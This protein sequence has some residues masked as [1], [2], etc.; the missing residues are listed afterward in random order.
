MLHITDECNT[1]NGGCSHTCTDTNESYKCSCRTGY[2]L[3]DDDHG[4][5][6]M[7]YNIYCSQIQVCD[8]ITVKYLS[9]SLT[10]LI[11]INECVNDTSGC[12][13]LCHNTIGSYYCTCE[14]GYYLGNDNHSC[15]GM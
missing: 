9:L 1:N 8:H 2:I 4:C 10:F 12:E 14:E 5:N 7:L 11:D 3:A 13:Q 15:L 6:G